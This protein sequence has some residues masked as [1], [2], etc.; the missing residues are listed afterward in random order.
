MEMVQNIEGRS[1]YQTGGAEGRKKRRNEQEKGNQEAGDRRK[2]AGGMEVGTG[3]RKPE[4]QARGKTQKQK[5][6]AGGR[7]RF[8]QIRVI[9][10]K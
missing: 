3:V 9:V 7:S 2:K 1:R 10:G 5:Q 6:K 8:K 4:Q